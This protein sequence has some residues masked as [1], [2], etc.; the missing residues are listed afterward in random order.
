M[1]PIRR[2]RPRPVSPQLDLPF[3][4]AWVDVQ[5]VAR[6]LH[7]HFRTRYR[8]TSRVE[9]HEAWRVIREASERWPGTRG[10]IVEEGS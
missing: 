1:R 10:R 9:A 2:D 7:P 8:W 4:V 3:P 6:K 5:F